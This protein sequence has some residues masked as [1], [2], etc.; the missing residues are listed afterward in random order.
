MPNSIPLREENNHAPHTISPR[1]PLIS[2][3]TI[4]LISLGVLAFLGLGFL[5][6]RYAALA[7]LDM[8]IASLQKKQTLGNHLTAEEKKE[9]LKAY[10]QKGKNIN[11]LDDYSWMPLCL[12]TPFV[13]D[14]PAPGRQNNAQINSMQFRSTR[15]VTTPKPNGY[16]RVF[17]TGGST[18]Y[19]SGAPSDDRTIGGYLEKK[20]HAKYPQTK[21]KTIEVFT[22]AS[23]AW[24]STHERIAIE[25][26]LS[27]LQPDMVISFSGNN[28]VHWGERGNNVLMFRT[29]F[30]K[31]IFNS[32]KYIYAQ[33]HAINLVDNLHPSSHPI[34]PAIVV[35]RLLKN[36]QIS[37]FTLN[38]SKIPYLFVLQP[39]LATVS[40]PL[41]NREKSILQKRISE[42]PKHQ[43]Y[44]ESCYKS[45][46]KSM[47][48]VT[49]DN[50]FNNLQYL[51][52]ANLFDD[53]GREEIF[54]D[55]YHFGD[56]G[57]EI[58]AE[59]IANKIV[60]VSNE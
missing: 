17:I 3:I 7:P 49:K 28:D 34:A 2:I 8:Q 23:P 11:S 40:K 35:E 50:Q 57:N 24:T 29:Y 31:N 54:I 59:A 37:A 44:F 9:V 51:N 13:G 10:Y 4:S 26:I 30:E 47:I 27:E 32:I 52:L 16:F 39:T 33:S 38:A 43:I 41:S 56:R 20:L 36:I 14:A 6:G 22:L 15:E 45:I 60:L 18:A 21:E 53:Y 19:G 55:S 12:I 46:D 25:N 48:S 42:L 58:I 1:N 5:G